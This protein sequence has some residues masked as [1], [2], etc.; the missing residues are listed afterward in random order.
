[1]KPLVFRRSLSSADVSWRAKRILGVGFLLAGCLGA[2]P[3]LMV[4][5]TQGA[6]RDVVYLG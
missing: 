5:S 3:S 2:H 1:V 4:Q 6:Q